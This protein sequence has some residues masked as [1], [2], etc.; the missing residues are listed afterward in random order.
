VNLPAK[1]TAEVRELEALGLQELRREWR[2]RY[3]P[4][5]KLRAV[6]L[7][8]RLL[9]WRIQA[10]ALGGLDRAFR[11]ALKAPEPRQPKVE[12][13]PGTRVGREWK[14]VRHEVEVLADGYAYAGRTYRSLSEVARTIT[15]TRWNGLRFFGLREK[16]G[17]R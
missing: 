8:R 6:E 16:E 17:A 7:L 12:L 4:P 10:D 15:G 3:G 2:R 5:P 13:Q 14:G 9:A 1:I 11:H